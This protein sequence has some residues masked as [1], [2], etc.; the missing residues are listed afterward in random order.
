MKP[1]A[2]LL[3]VFATA[4]YLPAAEGD[5]SPKAV[6]TPETDLLGN[7]L[8]TITKAEAEALVAR[9]QQAMADSNNNPRLSVDAAIA[10]S[11]SLKYYE[12]AGDTDKICDIEANI[13]WCK[14][15]MNLDD[16]KAFLQQKSGDKYAEAALA[17]ADSVVKREVTQE[18]AAEYFARA[19][20]FATRNPANFEQI[21]VRYF[22][23]AERFVGTEVGIKAQKLSLAAQQSQM[24]Q[25]KNAELAARSTL[26]NRPTKIAGGIKQASVP[27]AEDQKSALSSI[28]SL[29]KAD[30]AKKKTNQKKNLMDKLMAQSVSTKDDPVMLYGLLESAMDLAMECNEFYTVI[31]GCDR[32]SVAFTGVDAKEMKKKILGKSRNANVLAILKLL[33]NAEDADANSV[34]GKYFCYE[35]GKWDIGLPLLMHGSDV[36][37]KGLA[38]MEQL[39]PDGVAQQIEMGDKWYDIGKKGRAATKEG[40]FTRAQ[41]WYQK[42]EPKI[43]GI[44]K[45]RI[46][47][48]MD[49]I[50]SAIPM[51][52]LNY[53]NLTSKQWDRLRGGTAEI[54]ATRDRNDIGLR[55]TKGKRYRIV[56]HPTDTW[57]PS[58]YY[59]SQQSSVNYKGRDY[60]Y[61]ANGVTYSSGSSGDFMEGALVMQ[62]ENGK[63]FK[64]GILEGE[65]RV[66]MGPFSGYSWGAGG[67]GVIRVKIITADDE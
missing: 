11:K 54:S 27:S 19:E 20:K 15:R 35:A 25:I 64:P 10:F 57:A 60:T 47:K 9:G 24:K 30:F 36:L 18:Q 22:E 29:Y 53:D 23:V 16:I 17:K 52:N 65:G 48:R 55:L 49:E 50:D 7:A 33:D 61:I 28:R 32:M 45:D 5:D 3:V 44:S 4:V 63:W 8:Q 56:P 62:I 66:F 42:A 43:T 34:V 31:E 38:D 37:L 59:S 1:V 26:F 67:T 40:P 2:Y 14:K 12:Q 51:T 13:F 21:S 58:S 46:I 6:E 39:R 41:Y